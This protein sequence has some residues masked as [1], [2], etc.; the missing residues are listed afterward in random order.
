MQA[1]LLFRFNVIKYTFNIFLNKY[2][3]WTSVVENYSRTRV[4]GEG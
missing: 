1:L 2:W 3:Y 4:F